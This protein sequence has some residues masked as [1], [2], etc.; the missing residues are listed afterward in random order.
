M[1]RL[2]GFPL[3]FCEG[4]CFPWT[5]LTQRLFKAYN[6]DAPAAHGSRSSEGGGSGYGPG[7]ALEVVGGEGNCN[8]FLIIGT[9]GGSSV[10]TH[11]TEAGLLCIYYVFTV[12]TH[13]TEAGLLCI[14]YVF[15][16]YLP[17]ISLPG[18]WE[19]AFEPSKD[20]WRALSVSP[21][22][23]GALG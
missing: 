17:C 23:T 8:P 2:Q 19:T 12:N 7:G 9:E 4:K 16:M 3:C 10:N 22:A 11:L 14:Y 13:L 6:N 18:W 21:S 15:T 1:A 20:L 5:R